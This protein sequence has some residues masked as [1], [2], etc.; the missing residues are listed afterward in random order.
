MRYFLLAL[1]VIVIVASCS[2]DPKNTA[3]RENLLRAKKWKL[4]GGTITVKLP[5]R[6]DT[7]L[8]YLNFLPDCYKDDYLTFDSLRHGTVFTGGVSCNAADPA[9]HGFIWELSNNET[10]IDLYDGFNDLFGVNDTIQPYHFDTIQQSPLV[11]DTIIKTTDTTPGFLK[12]FI[13]LDTVRELRMTASRFP[14]FDIYKASITDFSDGAFT[15]HFTA[16]SYSPDSTGFHGGIPLNWP[17]IYRRD[18]FQYALKY[19]GF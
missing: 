17:P 3:N 11:L 1:S 18:T 8:Q 2:K 14:Q 9:S 4:V 6:K 19:S 5:S 15:L 10:L 12:T 13:V 7:V 16:V